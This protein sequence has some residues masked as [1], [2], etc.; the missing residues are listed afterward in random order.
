[1][2]L[3]YDAGIYDTLNIT[4]LLDVAW[5]L[6][7][8]FIL[9]ATATVHG[10]KVSLPNAGSAPSLATPDTKA[11]TIAADGRIYLD[12]VDVTL[13]ELETRLAGFKAANPKLPVVVRGDASVQYER[14]VQVLDVI[15]RVRI[16]ELGLATQGAVK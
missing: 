10:V 1:M 7:V 4:P 14:V 6:L 3:K 13:P 5:V 12:T 2:R 16:T 15:K 9:M 11:V 8:I